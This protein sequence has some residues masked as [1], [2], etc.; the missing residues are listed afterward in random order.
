MST[1]FKDWYNDFSE[2]QKENYNLC[3]K[4]PILVPHNCFTG[5]EV[6][7]F[8]YICTELDAMPGGWRKAFGEQWAKE[9]QEAVNKIPEP[10][11]SKIFIMQLKE[12]YGIF[13]QY[14]NY[15]NDD[16]REIIRKYEQLSKH[17]CIQCGAPATKV[18]TSWISPWCDECSESIQDVFVDV[19]DYWKEWEERDND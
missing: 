18:S 1:E 19:E 2:E 12:K 13:T 9:I 7:D 6:D 15:Y 16:L 11:R 14:L 3:M 5:K 10:D 17:T 4:Y 8:D